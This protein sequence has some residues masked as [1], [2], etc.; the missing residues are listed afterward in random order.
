[1]T[2]LIITT[3]KADIEEDI[4]IERKRYKL[5]IYGRTETTRTKR[6]VKN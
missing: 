2:M 6:V 3:K 4:E 1:M 5:K